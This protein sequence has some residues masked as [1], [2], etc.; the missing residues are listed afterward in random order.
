MNF[1]VESSKLAF[2]ALNQAFDEMGSEQVLNVSAFPEGP[3]SFFET[4]VKRSDA[5]LRS[6]LRRHVVDIFFDWLW[7]RHFLLNAV[8]AH[9][10]HGGKG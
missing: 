3:E 8:E 5:T 7:Q 2:L 1:A 6:F 9:V 4:A 10:E